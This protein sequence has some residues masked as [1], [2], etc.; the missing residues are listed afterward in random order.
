MVA[1]EAAVKKVPLRQVLKTTF[2]EMGSASMWVLCS[3]SF[4]YFTA[5][6]FLGDL[7]GQQ[8]DSPLALLPFQVVCK[9]ICCDGGT[10][11]R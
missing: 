8:D 11:C 2:K 9:D 1:A 7:D 5:T 10:V 4:Q 3:S 6:I